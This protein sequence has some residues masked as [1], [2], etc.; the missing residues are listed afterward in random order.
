LDI[1]LVQ[2]SN[3]LNGFT[4][5]N[6]TK[7]DVLTGLNTIRIG[8]KYKD[9]VTGKLLP[10]GSFP[11][12]LDDLANVEVQYEDLPGWTEDLSKARSFKDL[13]KAAQHYLNRVSELCGVPI[14][15]VGVGPGREDMFLM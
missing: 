11:A 3:T 7:L 4:S 14:S 10:E 9:K 2:Y 12:H 8:V 1:P 13:P 6:I 15:W 5:M